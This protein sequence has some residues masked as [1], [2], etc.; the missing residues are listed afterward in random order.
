MSK[1]STS[2]VTNFLRDHGVLPP[3]NGDFTWSHMI[4]FQ[5]GEG[6]VSRVWS[7]PHAGP[8][9]LVFSRL[10]AVNSVVERAVS[11]LVATLPRDG[12]A[13]VLVPNC[14]EGYVPLAIPPRLASA[15]TAMDPSGERIKIARRLAHFTGRVDIEWREGDT[16]PDVEL[17]DFTFVVLHD[18]DEIAD[19]PE[20]L[21]ALLRRCKRQ[22]FVVSTQ[23]WES[24]GVSWLQGGEEASMLDFSAGHLEG[25]WGAA[26]LLI[27]RQPP[28]EAS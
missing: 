8:E 17:F 10:V 14:R 5:I 6:D 26:N 7:E 27:V 19:I 15:I 24:E 4:R 11:H 12:S 13:N 23:N 20:F 2:F 21:S 18:D 9:N 1:E 22:M 3:D 16:A 28:R 25:P